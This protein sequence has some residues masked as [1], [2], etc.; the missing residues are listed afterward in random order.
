MSFVQAQ[1]KKAN[2]IVCDD[3]KVTV[4]LG[5]DNFLLGNY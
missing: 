4:K 2:K 3:K 5:L 1:I